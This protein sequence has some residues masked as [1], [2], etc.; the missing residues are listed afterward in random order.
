MRAHTIPYPSST[1]LLYGNHIAMNPNSSSAHSPP[2]RYGTQ[3]VKSYLDWHAN[4]LSATK[5]PNVKITASSTSLE[6]VNETMTEMQYA[7]MLVNPA[8]KSRLVGYDLRFQ[9]V[10]P[11]KTN[12]PM[13]EVHIIH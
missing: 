5:M 7:S 4:R 1:L 6:S 11:R 8:R 3:D 9:N 2:A 12:D 10:R 13:R